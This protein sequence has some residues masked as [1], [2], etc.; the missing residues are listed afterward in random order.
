MRCC[1]LRAELGHDGRV[2]VVNRER[3]A[4]ESP[5][6]TRFDLKSDLKAGLPYSIKHADEIGIA[7]GEDPG[8]AGAE[9]GHHL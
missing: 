6:E 7:A 3:L 2:R 9:E 8:A 4:Q 5:W 1:N